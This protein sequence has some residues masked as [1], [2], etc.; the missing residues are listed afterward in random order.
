MKKWLVIFVLGFLI[1][2]FICTTTETDFPVFEEQS[3]E[4]INSTDF[5]LKEIDVSS[6][7]ITTKNVISLLNK[8]VLKKAEYQIPKLYQKNFINFQPIYIWKGE[9]ML[10]GLQEIEEE[11][12][13]KMKSLGYQREVEKIYF[14]GVKLSKI[15]VYG[16]I[17]EIEVLEQK[18]KNI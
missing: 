13:L 8:V 16:K 14:Y 1:L 5:I 2:G 4:Y 11:L 3:L 9:T 10:Q 15:E 12:S 6:N 18:L 17:S 7:F